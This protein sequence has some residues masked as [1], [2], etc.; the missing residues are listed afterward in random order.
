VTGAIR[1]Y[2]D[3]G[4]PVG[5]YSNP[6]GWPEV[7]GSWRLAGYPTWSTAGYGHAR[8]ARRMCSR[9]PSGGVT[10]LAQWWR[11]HRDLDLVCPRAPRQ[12]RL[13]AGP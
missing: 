5:I 7:V 3:V 13:F 6:N 9:G 11:G 2:R 1:G 12:T 10:W 8:Q 4:Y